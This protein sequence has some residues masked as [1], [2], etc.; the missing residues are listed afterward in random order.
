[1]GLQHRRPRIAV[2]HGKWGLPSRWRWATALGQGK[3]GEGSVMSVAVRNTLMRK[4]DLY[5]VRVALPIS[6]MLPAYRNAL[7][8]RSAG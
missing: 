1:M 6:T 2:Q 5:N 3:W 8:Q 7:S 4:H